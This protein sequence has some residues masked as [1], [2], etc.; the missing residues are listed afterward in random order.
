MAAGV[1]RL[2][3][4]GGKVASRANTLEGIAMTCPALAARLLAFAT[5][6]FAQH[7]G[8]GR[9]RTATTGPPSAREFREVNAR[10]HRGMSIRFIGLPIAISRAA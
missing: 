3:G 1:T 4:H 7:A 10:M 9:P 6:A 8:H 5:P 2:P